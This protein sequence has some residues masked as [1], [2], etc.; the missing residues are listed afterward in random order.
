[1]APNLRPV[2]AGIALLLLYIIFSREPESKGKAPLTAHAEAEAGVLPAGVKEQLI[3][4][5]S[6]ATER[7]E[8]EVAKLKQHVLDARVWLQSGPRRRFDA[9]P[10][11]VC[12]RRGTC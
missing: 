8:N 2:T 6:V 11:A 10:R 1:M 5:L 4:E 12:G 9:L 7:L 3:L